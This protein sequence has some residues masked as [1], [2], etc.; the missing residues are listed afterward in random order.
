MSRSLVFVL[1][2][3][4]IVLVL[5]WLQVIPLGVTLILMAAVAIWIIYYNWLEHAGFWE[6]GFRKKMILDVVS[7]IGTMSNAIGAKKAEYVYVYE[8]AL[9]PVLF[10]NPIFINS[11]KTAALDGADVRIIAGPKIFLHLELLKLVMEGKVYLHLRKTEDLFNANW[12]KYIGKE[13]TNHFILVD[14]RAVWLEY[15]HAPGDCAG[16]Y[17][18]IGS[19]MVQQHCWEKFQSELPKT[20]LVKANKVLS[21]IGADNLIWGYDKRTKT[22]L[23]FPK[24]QMEKLRI[25]LGEKRGK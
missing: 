5:F 24:E 1:S 12:E 23:P 18:Y 6:L 22:W 10:S 9:T 25:T 7:F 13:L 8:G 11:L 2:G 3:V 19:S 21:S 15:I 20:E 16:G 14:G 17:E 4:A